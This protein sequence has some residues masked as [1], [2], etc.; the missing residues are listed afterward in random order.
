[1]TN[2]VDISRL[3]FGEMH[4]FFHYKTLEQAIKAKKIGKT[5]C[6]SRSFE[7]SFLMQGISRVIM[8]PTELKMQHTIHLEAKGGHLPRLYSALPSKCIVGCIF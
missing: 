7:V 1:M 6:K 8:N 3:A 4:I 2:A 5:S